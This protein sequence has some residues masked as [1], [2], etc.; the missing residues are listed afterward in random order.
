MGYLS[1]V[2]F[3]KLR[4]F[5]GNGQPWR[6]VA[7]LSPLFVAIAVGGWGPG[8]LCIMAPW[9][10]GCCRLVLGRLRAASAG[11]LGLAVFCGRRAAEQRG[12]LL[13]VGLTR[14]SDYWH[15]WSDIVTGLLLGL[16][17]AALVYRQCYP[18]VFDE[19]CDKEL[20]SPAGSSGNGRSGSRGRLVQYTVA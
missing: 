16:L 14:F 11:D 6:L 8:D 1:L 13:Q 10:P 9:L 19:E 5:D 12:L 17:V 18:S 4:T 15:H 7:S 2:L 3:A 20:P